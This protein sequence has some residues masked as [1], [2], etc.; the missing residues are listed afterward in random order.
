MLFLVGILS[1][2]IGLAIGIAW[3][4]KA[5][6]ATRV[7]LASEEGE[8]SQH[9]E[10][11]Q[12]GRFDGLFDLLAAIEAERSADFLEDW[13]RTAAAV[14]LNPKLHALHSHLESL[15]LDDLKSAVE[16]RY[17][18]GNPIKLN[19]GRFEYLLRF[20]IPEI[21]RRIK[22]IEEGEGLAS[23]TVREALH[24]FIR[25]VADQRFGAGH[26]ADAVEASLKEVNSRIK[27][28]VV[29]EIGQ[30]LDGARLMA[31]A[32]SLESPVIKLADLSSESGR[33]TQ[34]GF[35]QIFSGA[36]TGVRNPKAHANVDLE[37]IE[38]IHLLFLASLL[39]CM[40]EG[41]YQEEQ[42]KLQE[43][44]EPR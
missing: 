13:S 35:L 25:N 8:R 26:F 27:A 3:R 37:E 33:N 44:A 40:L 12:V 38:A 17:L 32:F 24:P 30:E 16:E 11:K 41:R 4:T 18:R 19:Y 39:M 2:L 15:G 14:R 10:A 31:R 34:L 43:A 28:I 1:G 42:A 29:R 7:R 6:Q 36:M 9:V 23:R 22:S 5:A 21:K 20:V